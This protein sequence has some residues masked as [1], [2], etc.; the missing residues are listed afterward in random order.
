MFRT[1]DLCLLPAGLR[2]KT[3]G[4]AATAWDLGIG[5]RELL[6]IPGRSLEHSAFETDPELKHRQDTGCE[7]ACHEV[8]G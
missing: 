3:S 1:E 6:V 8:L 7:Q 2:P 4:F 5:S